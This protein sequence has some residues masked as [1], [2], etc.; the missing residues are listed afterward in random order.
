MYLFS[1]TVL[2]LIYI[3]DR[4]GIFPFSDEIENDVNT[5]I[6]QKL[7]DEFIFDCRVA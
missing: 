6:D 5:D 7:R 1:V 4:Y 2:Q 3:E